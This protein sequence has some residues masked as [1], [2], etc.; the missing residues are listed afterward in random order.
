METK[1]NTRKEEQCY[2]MK[3][4]TTKK[5]KKKKTNKQI[6]IKQTKATTK[7]GAEVI[8]AFIYSNICALRKTMKRC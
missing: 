1:Q 6:N 3:Q 7:V 2:N 4:E 8:I 5:A